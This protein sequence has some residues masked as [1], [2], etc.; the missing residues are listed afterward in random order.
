VINKTRKL[1]GWGAKTSAEL[2]EQILTW[3]EFFDY[4][5]IPKDVGVYNELYLAC[6]SLR[7]AAIGRGE[8]PPVIDGT[9]LAS[10]WPSVKTEIEQ[11]RIRSGKYLTENAASTCQHCLGSGMRM[12]TKGGVEGVIKCDHTDIEPLFGEGGA[13]NGR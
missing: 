7:A 3:A 8:D 13:G 6:A 5:K 9:Y 2:N 12:V 10:Q 1:N 11:R 4:Q